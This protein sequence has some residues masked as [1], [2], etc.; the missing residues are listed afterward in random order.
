LF[1]SGCASKGRIVP[2]YPP[3]EWRLDSMGSW[4]RYSQ[5]GWTVDFGWEIDHIDPDGADEL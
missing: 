2:E 1:K 4:M 5:Y 3:T